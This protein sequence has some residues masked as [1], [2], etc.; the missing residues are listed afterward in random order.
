MKTLIIS[1]YLTTLLG[2]SQ[3]VA[4][5]QVR[6]PN[7]VWLVCE[8]QS[9][10]FS[11]YGDSVAHTP[12]LDRLANEG[13]VYDNFYCSAPVCAPARSTIITGMYQT[14]LGTH[15]MRAHNGWSKKGNEKLGLPVSRDFFSWIT[16]KAQIYTVS[17]IE[18]DLV[19]RNTWANVQVKSQS[20]VNVRK[21]QETGP[22][23]V[24][25]AI[26]DK[27]PTA[28]SQFYVLFKQ[29]DRSFE[30]CGR[31]EP[32]DTSTHDNCFRRSTQSDTESRFLAHTKG[33]CVHEKF[34][35]HHQTTTGSHGHHVL[36]A[37]K[38]VSSDHRTQRSR[39]LRT[40]E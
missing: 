1:L 33:C 17:V 8:D 39:H 38:I 14:A 10:F 26:N 20:T 32:T 36:Y 5:T 16:S 28:S 2:F 29:D 19:G 25:K 11:F 27:T 18:D 23:F 13:V 22:S 15:N 3:A 40:A 24:T 30:L 12:N 31:G 37:N 4:Q 21:Q 6:Q 7:I 35:E 34:E 9:P